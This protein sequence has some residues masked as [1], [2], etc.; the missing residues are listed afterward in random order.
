MRRAL[1]C[2]SPVFRGAFFM[3]FSLALLAG[4]SGPK[5][6]NESNFRKAIEA[7]IGRP[8]RVVVEELPRKLYGEV[9]GA[10]SPKAGDLVLRVQS[11]SSWP[12]AAAAR[13]LMEDL[14]EAGLVEAVCTD[15]PFGSWFPTRYSVYLLKKEKQKGLEFERDASGQD[16]GYGFLIGR[17]SVGS[18]ER[19]T[20]PADG[21]GVRMTTVEYTRGV[22]GA[23]K[24]AGRVLESAVSKDPETI[25]LVLTNRGWEAE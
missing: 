10:F 17:V 21:D 7:E 23:P 8:L 25:R 1:L 3:L 14:E 16:A 18:I 5:A 12:P 20:E 9:P 2:R 22:S 13:S 15:R 6:P 19:W 4:C 24:W 11:R